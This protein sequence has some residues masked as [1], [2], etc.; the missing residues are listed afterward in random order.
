MLN[1][2]FNYLLLI[3]TVVLLVIA[4]FVMSKKALA[5]KVTKLFNYGS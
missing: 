2:D 4:N 5:A 1:Q 3:L